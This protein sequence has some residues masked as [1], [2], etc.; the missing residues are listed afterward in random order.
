MTQEKFYAEKKA[1]ADEE[2]LLLKKYI[3]DEL[4][5]SSPNDIESFLQTIKHASKSKEF[6]EVKK[7]LTDIKTKAAEEK[8]KNELKDFESLIDKIENLED[9]FL[10]F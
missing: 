4:N 3:K 10:L 5:N 2:I 8:K 6:R 7:H 1:M 9:I